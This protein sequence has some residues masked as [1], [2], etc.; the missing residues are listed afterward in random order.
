M[1]LLMSGLVPKE[2]NGNMVFTII[3]CGYKIF[4]T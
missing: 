2:K 3:F 1:H 4:T